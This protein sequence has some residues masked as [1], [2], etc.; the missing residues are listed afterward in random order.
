MNS[1]ITPAQTGHRVAAE[2]K[3]LG[4]AIAGWRDVAALP[5]ACWLGDE[6]PR[7]G[8]LL[9]ICNVGGDFWRALKARGAL[10]S[11]DPMDEGSLGHTASVLDAVLGVPRVAAYPTPAGG[12][13]NLLALLRTLDWQQP[14]PLG[15]GIHADYGLWHAV[16][17]VWWLDCPAPA[18]DARVPAP[19]LCAHCTTQACIAACPGSALTVGQLP[20][21]SACADYRF[22]PESQCASGCVARTACPV[23]AGHRYDTDQIAHHYELATPAMAAYRG[24]SGA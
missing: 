7:T 12:S 20:T 5:A 18:A 2:L 19:D 11:P 15:L 1:S 22:A 4:L 24:D 16:R 14:S 8:S 10:D 3:A 6:V 17:A 13:V 9:V 23:G 21:L